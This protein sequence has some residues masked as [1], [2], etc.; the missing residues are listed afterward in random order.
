MEQNT[1]QPI[2]QT[3]NIP[4]DQIDIN[5]LDKT[6]KKH[7]YISILLLVF[8]YPIGVLYML[9]L[10]KWP[11][12][13]K[14]VLTIYMFILLASIIIIAIDPIGQFEQANDEKRQSDTMKILNAVEAY[15]ADNRGDLPK[16]IT[17][18]NREI[19]SFDAD[20]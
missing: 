7:T 4:N 5:S 2:P 1:N 17:T 12:W 16:G 14:A 13:L 11:K 8:I 9:F 18:A 19:S 6:E 3:Q 10:T 15:S 20:I